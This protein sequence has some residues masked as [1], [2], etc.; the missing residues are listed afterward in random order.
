MIVTEQKITI[1][2]TRKPKSQNIN[3][4]LKWLGASLGLFNLRDRDQ[5]CFRIFIELLKNAR[6]EKG[7]SSDELAYR[8]NLSRGTV[9]HH[10]NRLM[11]AGL[12]VAEKNRYALR[13][14]SLNSLIEEIE[15]DV[16]RTV[17]ELKKVA[18]ELD[19]Y[20]GL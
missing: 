3:E 5:S 14:D 19:K 1:I 4:S 13:V 12:V 11:K 15:L 6:V 17:N 20:L 2:S 7:V 18:K 10:I 8:L 9:V 16:T